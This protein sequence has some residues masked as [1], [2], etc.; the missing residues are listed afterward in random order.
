MYCYAWQPDYFEADLRT[1]AAHLT[2]DSTTVMGSNQ[3]GSCAKPVAAAAAVDA[4]VQNVVAGSPQ[5]LP[6]A[7]PK[8]AFEFDFNCSDP[9][10][11]F[12]PATQQLNFELDAAGVCNAMA[13]WFELQLDEHTCLSNS[14]YCKVQS[15][16]S[17]TWKQVG[18]QGRP[19]PAAVPCHGVATAIHIPKLQR[20]GDC[21]VC[22]TPLCNRTRYI[23]PWETGI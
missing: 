3:T 13:F 6:L 14:P 9:M 8:L 23:L 17:T 11:A 2:A 10:T 19:C 21:A 12:Q 20:C 7:S 1:S 4:A 18:G 5:W 15:G 22:S 16:S